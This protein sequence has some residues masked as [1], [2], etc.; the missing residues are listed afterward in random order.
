MD[1]D[2]ELNSVSNPDCLEI[3]Q[4]ATPASVK[5]TNFYNTGALLHLDEEW[6]A[7]FDG[8]GTHYVPPSLDAL[9]DVLI[10]EH[11]W[12]VQE[13]GGELGVL[14]YVVRNGLYLGSIMRLRNPLTRSFVADEENM[15]KYYLK[16]VCGADGSEVTL[17]IEV[18]GMNFSTVRQ[19]VHSYVGLH[20]E[21]QSGFQE[22]INT[23]EGKG[24][25]ELLSQPNWQ[26]Q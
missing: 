4:G 23:R 8:E 9:D 20:P 18:Q 1:Q 2:R 3:P 15:R 11:A 10:P 26:N 6:S 17:P 5:L 16:N 21:L 7:C 12:I 24:L 22:V 13:T 14:M 25:L 19:R